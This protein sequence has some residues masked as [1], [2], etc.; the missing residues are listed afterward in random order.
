MNVTL[1]RSL[2]AAAAAL[3]LTSGA[4]MAAGPFKLTSSAFADNAPLPAKYAGQDKSSPNCV[5][6]NIS[7]PLDW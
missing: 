6:E 7:P 2:L 3:L 1:G 5:G 4:A